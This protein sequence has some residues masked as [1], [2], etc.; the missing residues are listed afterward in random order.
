MFQAIWR[1]KARLSAFA[2]S[3]VAGLL[4][5]VVCGV[6][7]GLFARHAGRRAAE[8]RD[9]QNGPCA[10]RDAFASP[11]RVVDAIKS[12]DVGVRREAFGRLLALP[13]LKTAYYDYERDRDFPERAESVRLQRF[14]LD[15]SPDEE[16]LLTFVRVESPVAVV[17]KRGACGWRPVAAVSSWLK[18]ADYP[19]DEWIEAPEAVRAG[20]RVLLVRESTGD[21]TRYTRRARV[22]GLVGGRLEQFAEF[23]EESAG[24]LEGY[25]GAD[26][27]EVK[28]R[29]TASVA[30]EPQSGDAPALMRVKYV[31]EVVRYSGVEPPNVFWRE[32][33]GVWHEARRHWRAR[34]YEVLKRGAPVEEQFVWSDEKKRFVPAGS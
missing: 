6:L 17:L 23:E 22:L 14:N 31:E 3:F 25:A 13:G 8:K 20:T 15:D 16:A 18:S 2:L 21:A 11:E 32:G 24:P 5:V 9:A 27:A 34:R 12:E 28:R 4:V 33:D 30:F 26:W 1:L 29:R 7:F 10:S 19:Y